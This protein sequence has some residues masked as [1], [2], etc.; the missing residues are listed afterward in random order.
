MSSLTYSPDAGSQVAEARRRARL[1]QKGLAEKLGIS[2]WDLDQLERGERDVSAHVMAIRMATGLAL[3]PSE[4]S[5]QPGSQDTPREA[6]IGRSALG[7]SQIAGR[8]ALVAAAIALLVL[9]R[10]FTEVKPILP[11]AANFIDVPLFVVLSVAGLIAVSSVVT[12]R[13][14]YL[15]VAAPVMLFLGVC[16][17]S[18]AVNL[19][20]VEPGPVLVFLYGFLAPFGVYAAVYR[21]WPAGRAISLSRLLVALGVVQLLVVLTI[22]LPRFI[23]SGHNPDVISGTFGTNAYQLVFFMLVVIALL[24]TMLTCEPGRLV[25]RFAPVLLLLMLVTIFLAQ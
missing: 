20:R 2:L 13:R 5:V 24:A 4:I 18:V 17:V 10:F 8:L 3:R 25:S 22:D 1:S 7:A 21:L 15:R 9:I 16:A 11:R 6:T 14:S 12:S 23:S 19:T